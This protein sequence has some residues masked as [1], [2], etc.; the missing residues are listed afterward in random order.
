MISK[1]RRDWTQASGSTVP[2]GHTGAVSATSARSPARMA[3][4]YPNGIS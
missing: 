1:H 2:S 4:Q 3:R